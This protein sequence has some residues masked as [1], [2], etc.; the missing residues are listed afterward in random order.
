MKGFTFACIAVSL[1]FGFGVAHAQEAPK[2]PA[3]QK[4]HEW[5]KLLVGEWES[6]SECI[7]EPGKPPVK[8]KGTESARS[9]G[10][11]WVLGEGKSE[12]GGMKFSNVLT[13]GYDPEKKK[14]VG[15]WVDSLTSVLWKY[16]GTVDATGKILTLE[17]EGPCPMA[18]GKI[19]KFKE[20]IEFK[21]PDHK[22]FTSSM[23]GDDGKWV[24]FVTVNSKRKK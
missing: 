11:F 22:V 19:S 12:M 2:L 17:T 15:T 20:V 13:I 8:A 9:L 4:E 16:E 3:P 24:T 18:P 7:A 21:T 10:G 1:L 14:Y 5:L 23:Q 6:E